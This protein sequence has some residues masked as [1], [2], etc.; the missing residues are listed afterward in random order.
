[1]LA[2]VLLVG[3]GWSTADYLNAVEEIEQL[4]FHACY[5]GTICSLT[6][7]TPT[8]EPLSRG[9]CCLRCQC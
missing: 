4:G 9:R 1:M 3:W 6:K 2:S 7:P 5:I 8:L